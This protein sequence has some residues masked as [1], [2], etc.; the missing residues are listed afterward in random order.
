ML[1][2]L[3]NRPIRPLCS[4]VITQR[5]TVPEPLGSKL[6]RVRLVARKGLMNSTVMSM[7]SGVDPV[8]SMLP[9]PALR[10]PVQ[11]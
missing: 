5:T 9:F 11:A 1:I 8:I 3:P 2:T 7:P 10:L 6:S 4:P